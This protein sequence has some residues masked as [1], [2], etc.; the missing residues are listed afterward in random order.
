MKFLN[1]QD[2]GNNIMKALQA[3]C[4]SDGAG[5]TVTLAA[6]KPAQLSRQ[7]CDLTH[8]RGSR[9]QRQLGTL[10]RK[11][12]LPLVLVKRNRSRC[13]GLGAC[14][15]L[16]MLD[17][18]GHHQVNSETVLPHRAITELA[19][20]DAANAFAGLVILLVHPTFVFHVD[21]FDRLLVLIDFE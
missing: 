4:E 15:F 10:Q 11:H 14:Q 6:E 17:S 13:L 8:A 5:F 16:N 19:V 21:L 7:A 9:W 18:P 3:T 2:S 12:R 1:E 20:L